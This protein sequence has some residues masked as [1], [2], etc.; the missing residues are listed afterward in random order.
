MNPA[1]PTRIAM[2]VWRVKF[3]VVGK[4]LLA[5]PKALHALASASPGLGQAWR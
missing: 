2:W 4:F 1:S 3:F 5:E